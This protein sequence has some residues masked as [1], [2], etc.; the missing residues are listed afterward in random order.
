MVLGITGKYCAGKSTV[1]AI[2]EARGFFQIEVDQLGHVA[3]E[4]RKEQVT[5]RFGRSVLEGGGRDLAAAID[6]RALGAIVFNDE[7]ARRDLE[8]IVHPQMVLMVEELIAAHPDRDIIINAAILY[9]MKLDRL[10]DALLWVDAP[11]LIRVYRAIRRDHL[12]LRQVMNRFRSQTDMNGRPAQFSSRNVDTK[13]VMN[14]CGLN[15]LTRDVER[16]L[17]S[18]RAGVSE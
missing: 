3:L 8:A 13:R 18:Y 11:T 14:T 16:I 10:C 17:I 15:R 1:A 12:S 6:R 5:G 4:R 7:A 9:R 2:V